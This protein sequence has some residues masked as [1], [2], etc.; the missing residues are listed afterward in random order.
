[1]P[2]EIALFWLVVAGFLV[3][4]NLVLVPAGCDLLRFGRRGAIWYDAGARLSAARRELVLLNPL[5][6]FDRALITTR[7]F[8]DIEPRQWRQGRS[9][10]RSML[11]PLNGLSLL[12]Y[13][14]LVLTVCLAVLSFHVPFAPVLLGFAALHALMW[15]LNVVALICLRHR[16]QLSGY[17]TFV[18]CAEAGFVPAYLMNMG[19]RV[20]H[21]KRVDIPSLG[22]GLRELKRTTD[23]GER[24]WRAMRLQERLQWLC[25][26]QGHERDEV[27]VTAGLAPG[28]LSATQHWIMKA[29]AC[30]K[31]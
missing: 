20:L 25:M 8:G 9:L 2:H 30:L 15:A 16:L 4:D 24:E 14:Y 19:K 23:E 13:A 31:S 28:R 11:S 26:T 3:A 29:E 5:N 6:L 17:E 21:K 22:M 10:V 1:M 12:G 18:L 27:A 7:C